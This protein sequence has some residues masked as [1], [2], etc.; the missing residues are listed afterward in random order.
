MIKCAIDDQSLKQIK[1]MTA[2][3]LRNFLKEHEP[4][5]TLKSNMKDLFKTISEQ[6]ELSQVRTIAEVINNTASRYGILEQVPDFL[7]IDSITNLITAIDQNVQINDSLEA[8]SDQIFDVQQVRTRLEANREFLDKAYGL[9]KDVLIYA[10]NQANQNI[11][12]CCFINRGSVTTR[13][14]IT[15]NTSE[16]NSNIREYQNMLLRKIITY[17]KGI[18]RESPNLRIDDTVKRALRLPSMYDQDNKYTGILETLKP[19]LNMYLTDIKSDQLMQLFNDMNNTT[20][21]QT[22]RLKSQQRLDAYNAYVLLQNFDTYLT[23]TLGKVIQIK[24]FNQKTG[25]DKYQI[26]DKTA[27]LATTW[28]VSEN[29]DVEAE[30]DAITKLAI[31]TTPIIKWQSSVPMNGKF[32]HFSDFQH[33]VAKIKDLTYLPISSSIVFNQEFI[34]DNNELWNQLSTNTRNFLKDRSLSSAINYIRR[35]P[36]KYTHLIF[37]IL[38]NQ[39]FSYTFP[40]LYKGFTKDELDK[41]YSISQGIFTG[42]NSLYRLT[43]GDFTTDYYSFITQTVDS[44]FNVRYIQY[45]RDQ[46]GVIQV[47][48]LI[49]QGIN[50]IRRGIEQTINTSNSGKLIK[51]WDEYKKSLKI[52]PTYVGDR[53]QSIS[54]VLPNTDTTITVLAN[55]CDVRITSRE[56]I[57][58][59]AKL[60]T[61]NL[62]FIDQILKL[63]LQNN[64][65][66]QQA[67]IEQF[68]DLTNMSR[69]L[70]QFAS[71]VVFNQYVQ[72]EFLKNK[73][74]SEKEELLDVLYG[75][76]APRYN[77]VLDE[78]GL[79]HGNDIRTLNTIAVAKANVQGLTI[80]SQVKDGEGHGQSQQTLSRLLGSLQSQFEMQERSKDSVT[81]D[82][83]L[84]NIPG[85]FEGVYTTKEFNDQSEG[86]KSSTDMNVSEMAYSQIV[87]DFVG[88]LMQREEPYTVGNN[89]ILLLPSV[90]SD[91]STIGRIKINLNTVV[92]ITNPNTGQIISK[93]LKDYKPQELEWLISRELGTMYSKMYNKIVKDWSILDEVIQQ[94]FPDAPKLSS[95]FVNGFQ[96]FNSWFF[97]NQTRLL[98]Y[99]KN[100]SEFIKYF[101]L[102]Y[103]KTHRLNPLTFIDQVHYKNNK[104]S[105][106]IN[107]SIIAQ[108]ARFNPQHAIFKD[109]PELL[110]QYPTASEFW[111]A[112]KAEVLKTLLKNDFKINTTNSNQLELQFIRDNYKGWINNSGDLILA[113]V[114][115][116]GQ[117]INIS[118]ARDLL[119]LGYE[120]TNDIINSVAPTLQLNPIL[121]QYNYLDYLLTQEFMDST[122]GSFIAHPEKSKSNNILYQEAAHFQAQHKRNVSF[123]A[124][125]H[126]FQLNLLNGIPEYYNL[127]VI[128]DITDQQGT[129]IGIDSDIKPFDGA[130]FVNPFVVILENNSLG[131]ARAGITKKQFVHFKNESTGTGGIIKTAG[132]GLTN[133]WIRNS[134][135][136]EKMMRKMTNHIWLNEDGSQ[137]TVDITRDY[138]GSKI[139]YKDL[140]FKENGK[141]YKI[142]N[143]QSLGNNLYRRQIEEV[144][145]YGTPIGS[146]ISQDVLVNTNYLL[147]NLFGGKNSMIIKNNTLELSNTSVENVVIAMNNT[148]SLDAFGNPIIKD[149]AL[150]T[151]DDLW[152]PLKHVDVHYLA[153][154]GAVKQGA[155][156]INSAS[157]YTDEISYDTQRIRMY[158]AGIQLDKEHHA[159]NSELSLMTQVISA[160]AAKG[161]TIDQATNL[162]RA[163]RT[164]TDIKSKDHLNAVKNLFTDGSEQSVEQFQEV[165]M[166]SLIK[167]L[168]TQNS[169]SFAKSI[170]I[171]LIKQAKEGKNIKFSEVLLPLSD[172]TVYSKVFSTVSSYLTNSGIKQAIPGILSVLTPSYDIFKLYAG[173]K[174]ESF[175]NPQ[176]ELAEIQAQQVPVYDVNDTNSNISNLELGRTYI[177]TREY[178]EDIQDDNGNITSVT[179]VSE[180]PQLIRTPNEYKKLKEEIS[181]GI[182]TKVVEDVTAG[183]NLA[184]YNVRFNTNKGRFQIWDLDSAS[185]L[186]ELNDL[187]EQWEKVPNNIQV[188]SEIYSKYT[189]VVPIIT[190]E[191]AESALKALT[192]RMRRMLQNDLMNLSKTTPNVI[193]Q[194]RQLVEQ[195]ENTREWY[196]KFAQWVNIKL[197]RSDGSA[198]RLKGQ[199]ITVDENNFSDVFSQVIQLLAHT[200]QVRINGEYHNI[201]K[202]S[203]I[204]QAYEIIMPKVF[205]TAFGL[206]EFDDLNVIQN[207]RD[208]FI[209]QYLRNQETKV[210]PNQYTLEFKSSKGS[211]IYLLNSKFVRNSGLRKLENVLTINED[212]STYRTDSEGNIMYQISPDSEIYVDELGNEVIVSD[213]N[214]FYINNLTYDSIKLSN[215]LINFPSVVNSII[216]SLKTSSNKMARQF[217]SYITSI[218][219]TTQQVLASN[220]E[221]HS[222][223]LD[224]YTQLPETNPIIRAGRAK[225]TSFLRSLDIV[226]A[227]I[228]AQSQQSYMPMKVVA[229]DNPDINTA[230]VS[231]YQ[232]LLQGSDYDV[233][234]VSLAT[235]DI[236]ENG[237]LQ[238]WSPYANLQSEDFRVASEELPFPS[239]I[240]GHIYETD[241]VQEVIDFFQKYGSLFQVRPLRVFNKETKNWDNSNDAVDINFELDSPLKIHNLAKFLKEVQNVPIPSKSYMQQF[242]QKFITIQNF[243]P[244]SEQQVLSIFQSI[245]DIINQHNL[246]LDRVSN[247]RLSKIVNNYT[248]KQMYDIILDPVNLI[249]A[250]TSVD[251]TTGPLKN[252][253][254]K[255]NEGAEAKNRTPGNFTNKYQSIVENQV[256][257]EAIAICA[258]GLKAFFGLTQYNNYVLNYGTSEQQGRLLLGSDHRG[259]IIGG[260]LYKT[261]ANI[262][263]KDPN[264]IVNSDVLQALSEVNN[265]NDAALV[266]SALL[267]LATD[268]A[269]ELALSKLNA[270][271][272]TIG[273]YIYGITIGM[274]FRDIAKLLMSDAGGVITSLLEGDVFTGK[275]EYTKASQVFTYFEKCPNRIL[276]KY[277]ING[278]EIGESPLE[279]FRNQ[280]SNQESQL[281]D[282]KGNQLPLDIAL[283]TFASSNVQ[284][285]EKLN[286]IENLRNSYKSRSAQAVEIYNQLIDF[287]EDYIRQCH[288]VSSNSQVL[289]DLQVLAKGADEMRRLGSIF[290]LNQG[291]K[292]D[293]EGL[294]RQVNLIE[295]AIY[296][297]TEDLEDIIDLVKFAFDEEYR[298]KMILKYEE[299]KH[300]F[301]ILDAVSSVPHFL[302]YVQMLATSLMEARSSFKFRSTKTMSLELSRLIGY[303]DEN[304]IIK[305]IQNYVGDYL[306][307]QWMLQSDIKFTIPK[308]N[309][310]F[311]KNGNQYELTQDT[312]VKLGTDWGDATFR[313]FVENQIIPDLKSGIIKPNIQFP[314]ISK[315]KFIQ[316]LGNDLLTNT[317]SKNP[318]IV[319]TLPINML[320]RI[321]QERALLNQYKAEFNKLAQ[322]GYQYQISS[323]NENG[324]EIKSLS[325]PYSIVDIFTYY[326]MIANSWKLSEKSLIP[327]LEDFQNTGIIKNFHEF[328]ALYDKFEQPLSLSNTQYEELVPY[329]APYQSPYSSYVQDIWYRNPN[330][331]KVQLMHKMSRQEMEMEADQGDTYGRNP[332]IISKYRFSSESIDTNYFPVGQ[333][334]QSI[335]SVEHSYID[336][337]KTITFQVQYD[338]DSGYI[339][340]ILVGA[341][342]LQLK[343]LKQVPIIKQNGIKKVDVNLLES[344]I[345]SKL[346]PC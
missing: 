300:S 86:S 95:D 191:N 282:S 213:D 6:Y 67:L 115:I 32:L 301:N 205:A 330:T 334:E 201:D 88:G 38:T 270:S 343:E 332:N 322:Y 64:T 104:G 296:D 272:K 327:I 283:A 239:G 261:L 76:N 192:I 232:I 175:T 165:M 81:S 273:M 160:C 178:T 156:N 91:K 187:S 206:S 69:N 74:L 167:A 35:N 238:L 199:L 140:Y 341:D 33:T 323:L 122:V 44:I 82:F 233:D 168:S 133:D 119:R 324:E 183:R 108:I 12:D 304:R 181:Q 20:I 54:F 4:I 85:L 263:T 124:A 219:T 111:I 19:L 190:P 79:V 52:T 59:Y 92:S 266:L 146:E 78:L 56:N 40:E 87:Y 132:F 250:Q 309:K 243:I 267:S 116:N 113:K 297:T 171:D 29:I 126:A 114:N 200:Q 157:K 198:I 318:T 49:D 180:L 246:Y 210:Q 278:E 143:I 208:F 8:S 241:N 222:V 173:R 5:A 289:E 237:L 249:Q 185:A 43:G 60:Y 337:D 293:I 275:E 117:I 148:A 217:C 346:N 170:S 320:P 150:Q 240:E 344:I 34:R 340:K 23:L 195:R 127:A 345:K 179:R 162:Y 155:A 62:P 302:G 339:Q 303:R 342:I 338:I 247:S 313:M 214:E 216:D 305:G 134:P 331:R 121:E 149:N 42:N 177:V 120:N 129:I 319:Y 196:N 264:S 212:G 317:V 141:Y 159:D 123:T 161:Y 71:R 24:D 265:D 245:Q 186:F 110:Q 251:G 164:S 61:D 55:S 262:R 70:L 31:N 176:Q 1:N 154:A 284:L 211:H 279:H 316:D 68:G 209:K 207:D 194:F 112:K 109:N 268:N 48:T 46:D 271:T 333:L 153:T 21:D 139:V 294:L 286:S 135:F 66:F 3:V 252:E 107:K 228:P 2:R 84:L 25:Q 280:F 274:D 30:A 328:E 11:F 242:I 22:Q 218:G 96:N 220:N 184:G 248:M 106:G 174:Y 13:V 231:T 193:T 321:D 314:G 89:H 93:P 50:N 281:K 138:R 14:G 47:R 152:Q 234:A 39:D 103:N 53:L 291:I 329:V 16:L 244:K 158:Q 37:E 118:S 202:S 10:Q 101:T 98:P 310:A 315:N 65:N 163:L 223:T 221:Y 285:S 83:I 77:H 73:S 136:L 182:V 28:R 26:S 292:T 57:L 142:T 225:H 17:L 166:K 258:T 287:V 105:L 276:S 128:D 204:T 147:W 325:Q 229:Y 308:G 80:S 203:I 63:N 172:N 295:R 125:M 235:F 277:D 51:N 144:N 307:K 130:T 102:E 257:K 306:R 72:N 312:V 188:L 45:Y 131:G 299:I 27:K 260:K 41:L 100:A 36:R 97:L 137:A 7:N 255:S 145:I 94:I 99:G 226:A 215:Q 227:R 58:N 75:R 256:G 90:N 326:A 224:N 290:S 236:D 311:D 151:Q 169:D 288:I 9:A 18:V 336:G 189:G 197:G 259:H 269:K 253:T 230:Y 15:R 335:R 298:K 254:K